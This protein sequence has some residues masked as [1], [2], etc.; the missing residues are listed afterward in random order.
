LPGGIVTN[1]LAVAT[2]EIRY[3]I[4]VNVFVEADNRA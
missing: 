3:P 4:A 2:V 1:V